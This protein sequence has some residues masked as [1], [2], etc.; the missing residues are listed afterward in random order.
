MFTVLKRVIALFALV[1]VAIRGIFSFLSW[2]EKQEDPAE[3][4]WVD[5]DESAE[6]FEEV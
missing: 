5:S 2:V 6:E 1:A 4:L 3:S